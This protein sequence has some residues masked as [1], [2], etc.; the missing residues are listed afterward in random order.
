MTLY[1]LSGRF[2]DLYQMELEDQDS[3]IQAFD[4]LMQE[5]KDY[6]GNKADGYGSLIKT[7][8]SEADAF[9]TE[10]KRMEAQKKA[11]L[12]KVAR[13]KVN[14]ELYMATLKI[15]HIDGTLFK[16]VMQK[17]PPSLKIAD[18]NI[19]PENFYKIVKSPDKVALKEAIKNGEVIIGC[20]LEQTESVRIK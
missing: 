10:I 15:D 16:M 8:E 5:L 9:S 17:N 2:L 18:E 3:E 20:S 1:N 19:L 14:L 4:Q 6:E 12:N 13:L 7:L 11:R